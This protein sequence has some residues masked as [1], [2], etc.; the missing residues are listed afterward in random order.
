MSSLPEPL[1]NLIILAGKLPQ[2]L[3]LPYMVC[4]MEIEEKGLPAR[5][6]RPIA[7]R[8]LTRH[9]CIVH[10]AKPGGDMHLGLI[11]P[12]QKLLKTKHAIARLYQ[13]FGPATV[14]LTIAGHQ[15]WDLQ[16]LEKNVPVHDDVANHPIQTVAL[17]GELQHAI[18]VA[19][20][21]A[22]HFDNSCIALKRAGK[23]DWT[24]HTFSFDP[25]STHLFYY[26]GTSPICLSR[27]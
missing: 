13:L 3:G 9:G 4:L 20:A 6:G 1:N 26:I 12:R 11:E 8:Y 23:L 5:C 16:H 2:K 25:Q 19:Q 22:L 21:L 18:R 14:T 10:A 7:V 17:E 15:R 24:D 27:F